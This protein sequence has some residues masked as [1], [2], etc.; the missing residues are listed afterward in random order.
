MFSQL[1]QFGLGLIWQLED[2]P[3]IDNNDISPY[4]DINMVQRVIQTSGKKSYS[5]HGSCLGL[6]VLRSV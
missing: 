2:H 1:R 4:S 6:L 5:G 3:L